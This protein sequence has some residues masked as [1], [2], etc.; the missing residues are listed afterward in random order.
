MR[1]MIV[2]IVLVSALFHIANGAD[3]IPVSS[4][5]EDTALGR[6][7]ITA[8]WKI[9]PRCVLAR[10]PS[11]SFD[12]NVVGDPCIVWDDAINSWR[13][14]YFAAG[15]DTS[16]SCATTGIA[17]S[18]SAEEIGPGDWEKLGPIEFVNP[19]VLMNPRGHHKFWIILNP[20]EYN[21]P[22]RIEGKYWAVFTVSTP[23]KHLQVA[24]TKR[25]SG[26]W[27][28]REKPILS[29]DANFLDGKH[30]DTPTAYWFENKK[31]VAVFYKGYP[32]Y[33]QEKTQPG[34]PFGSGTILAYWHPDDTL[35]KKVG[36]LQ[37]P[38][39]NEAWNQGWMST[40]MI[41]YDKDNE[42]WYGLINGSPTAPLDDSHR[43]PAPSL[44]GWVVC[45]GKELHNIWRPDTLNSPFKY[46]DDLTEK[47]REAGLGVNFWRHHLL[48]TP[49]GQARIFFNSGA[50][51]KEQMYSLIRT[52]S[53]AT[54][55]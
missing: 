2:V 30:C 38:G 35:A 47:E 34:S 41:F 23:E 26:P 27:T 33:T 42:Q 37:R 32:K 7:F 20:Y 29:P 28:V 44:G 45:K 8:Q 43:E 40:P 39:Q 6:R 3:K 46:P 22:A 54:T 36:V 24:F 12:S 51:G 19:E 17:K 14:F 18:R 15:R 4:S 31:T 16:G 5:G 11:N 55:D 53:E 49:G 25:L 9:D 50:Y 48:V 1:K 10:G 21:T 13:M 52:T